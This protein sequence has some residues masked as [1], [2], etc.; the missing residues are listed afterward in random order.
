MLFQDH[1]LG[2]VVLVETEFSIV[3][4]LFHYIYIYI[5]NKYIFNPDL[6]HC[7]EILYQLSHQGSPGILEWVAYPYAGGSS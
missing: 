4:R 7:R 1:N 2:P 6:L 5:Y 3:S